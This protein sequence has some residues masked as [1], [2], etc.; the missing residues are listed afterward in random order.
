MPPGRESDGGGSSPPFREERRIVTALFVDVVGSTRLAES[1]DPEDAKLIVNEAVARAIRAVERYGGT[2]KD[3]AGDGVLALFGAPVAHEDD[4]ERALR[5]AL[6]IV[7]AALEQGEEVRRGWGIEGFAVRAGIATGYA[8][9]GPVGT[10]SRIEYGAV[11]DPVNVAARLQAVADPGQVLVA[12]ATVRQAGD[13]FKWDEPQKLNLKGKSHAVAVRRLDGLAPRV[14]QLREAGAASL[15]G[16]E[17]ELAAGLQL[18]EGLSRGQGGILVLTGEPGIGKSRLIA[19]LRVQAQESGVSWFE[20]RCVSYGE[21]MPYWPYRELLRDWLDVG[22]REASMRVRVGL[23]RYL[24]QVFGE[25]HEEALPYLAGMLG[26]TLEPEAAAH[27]DHMSP[28]SRQFRTFEV[29][30]ELLAGLAA[31]RPL[32]VVLEDV[33]WA[34]AT[35]VALTERLLELAERAAVLIVISQRPERDHASWSLRERAVREYPHLLRILELEPLPVE[36]TR[37]LLDGLAGQADLDEELRVRAVGLADGN[38]FYLEEIVRSLRDEGE[39]GVPQTVEEVVLARIDRLPPEAHD[40]ITAASI[41]GRSFSL[42][43]L[44]A[45][46]AGQAEDVRASIS[47]LQRHDLLREERRWPEPEYRFRHALIQETA[48]GTLVSSRRRQLHRRVAEWLEDRHAGNP[49]EV[50]ALLAHHWLAADDEERAIRYLGLAGDRDRDH[51]ALDEAIAHYRAQVDL[52]ERAERRQ[53]A[54][55][56]LFKLALALHVDMRYAEAQATWTRAFKSWRPPAAARV[57]PEAVL[58]IASQ[59]IPNEP[60]PHASN[61]WVNIQFCMQLGDR[62]VEAGEHFNV[63]PSL[64]ESWTVSE[65]GLR[66]ELRLREDARWNDGRPLTAPDVVASV[67]RG[68][69]P[70]QPGASVSVY[71]ALAGAEDYLEGRISDPEQLGVRALD[72]R[73]VEFR[74]IAPAPYFMAVLNRPDANAH[75]A[76]AGSGP[77]QVEKIE[78]DLVLL[79]RAPGYAG[80][81]GGN[82]ARIEWRRLP[83]LEA[84]DAFGRDEVDLIL[85]RTSPLPEDLAQAAAGAAP[86]FT[87]FAVFNCTAAGAS[88]E[89]RRALA[90]AID[91]QA[92]AKLAGSLAVAAT[93]GLVPPALQGHTPDIGIRLNPARAQVELLASGQQGRIRLATVPAWRELA[94]HLA[95]G[96]QEILGRDVEVEEIPG[97]KVLGPDDAD[98]A[99]MNWLP[100]YPDAEYYLRILL[101]SRSRAN[102]GRWSNPEFDGLIDLGRRERTG[103]ARIARLHAADRLA[104]AEEC[105]LAPLIYYRPVF[106]SKP[107]LRGYWEWGKSSASLADLVVESPSAV[108]SGLQASSDKTLE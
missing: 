1:L 25:R 28:E 108:A 79:E 76:D 12:E 66:Y 101:D 69:D 75:R 23:R 53:Q 15:V 48:A 93:G 47:L 22:P 24:E 83:I 106:L 9:L 87:V 102:H 11:G 98:V 105:A 37:R 6:E 18:V 26:L 44:Q 86:T 52:L 10:G 40:L 104:I 59:A 21:A 95:R 71:L 39:L 73:S 20:G 74:L 38:P 33:H 97:L 68:L 56:T 63:M 14:S 45:V 94:D 5:A 34:D 41:L 60:D 90:H 13:G 30:E 84:L 77:F 54:A 92:L 65:D 2:V 88:R 96:W 8:V 78:E 27:L 61:S 36:E 99:I 67:R 80:R 64:A 42:T 32:A 72:T 89:F 4:P 55:T 70:A 85:D 7:D 29:M 100:G 17:A 3:L 50:Y 82:V 91:H 43:L 46:A 107:S 103:A 16:R 81:R 51:W 57:S 19:E 58:R 49:E 31:A 35:S 62:L